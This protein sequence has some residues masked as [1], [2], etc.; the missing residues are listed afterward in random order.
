MLSICDAV[1]E[2]EKLDCNIYYAES[3]FQMK[4]YRKAANIYK[5]I[6]SIKKNSAKSKPL[7]TNE[8]K[9]DIS[10]AELSYKLY[11]CYVEMKQHKLAL[12]ALQQIPGTFTD[13]TVL[14]FV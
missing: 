9:K 4:Q 8:N 6:I 3:L 1:S 13:I 11:L 10:E 14:F 7:N 2:A 12:N 5:T